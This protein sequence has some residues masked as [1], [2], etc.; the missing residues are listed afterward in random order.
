VSSASH[1]SFARFNS[2]STTAAAPGENA[3]DAASQAG[4]TDIADLSPLEIEQIPEKIGYLKELGLDYGWGPSSMMEWIIEHTYMW[5]GLP[6]WASIV[7][8]G[9]LIRLAL[10]K[11][12]I[13]AADN[14]SKIQAIRGQSE[15][16]RQR[17]T[18]HARDGNNLELAKV[19]AEMQDLHR[20]HGIKTWKSLVPMLQIPLGYGC[21]RVVRGMA[22]LPVPG[23][24]TESVG[25]LT[26]LT[27]RD[28]YF[29]LPVATAVFMYLT[30]KVCAD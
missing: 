3:A 18:Y 1:L 11:P 17:M 7:T 12:S 8:A 20:Q 2:T 26:D 30:F 27:V 23:L 4:S 10:L 19:R 16:L 28:P 6:W 24:A 29:L 5:T 21:F 15:P 9:L 25:W 13:M 22:A 14:G